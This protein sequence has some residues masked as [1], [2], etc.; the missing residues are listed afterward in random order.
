[1]LLLANLLAVFAF[2]VKGLAGFGPALFIV[3]VLGLFWPLKQV[4]PYTAFLLFLANL[5]MLWLVRGGLEPRRDIPA[6]LAYALGIVLGTR[7]L[8]AAPETWLRF[9]LGLVLLVFALWSLVRLPGPGAAPEPSVAEQLRL[10]AVMLTGGLMAGAL[11]AG[12]LPLFV[13]LPLRYP[14]ESM[15]ALFT[16]AFGLGTLVW[17]LANWQ[18]G[19]LTWPLARLALLTVPGMLAGLALGTWLFARLPDKGRVRAVALL[20]VPVAL[21]LMGAF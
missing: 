16:S 4:V 20:L 1:M 3:P 19:L 21:R 15:R 12:A 17:T 11:G 7:L 18:A 14:P 10:G 6:A 9:A 5:P 2:A 13:Y 8:I